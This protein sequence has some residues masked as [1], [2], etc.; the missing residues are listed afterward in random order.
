MYFGFLHAK[1]V[2][3]AEIRRQLV[4]DCVGKKV[5]NRASATKWRSD[6]KSG[7][8]G[9]M[10]NEGR[11][12]PTKTLAALQVDDLRTSAIQPRSRAE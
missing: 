2:S 8:V 10:D 3:A 4:E 7:R 12:R 5:M 6:Y 1:H 11:G 9:T